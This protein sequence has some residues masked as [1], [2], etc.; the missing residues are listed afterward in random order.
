[1]VISIHFLIKCVTTKGSKQNMLVSKEKK[2]YG[3]D[4]WQTFNVC[5]D[6]FVL[7]KGPKCC[8]QG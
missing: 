5:I 6:A 1:M 3:N 4:T 2:K 8:N 7:A